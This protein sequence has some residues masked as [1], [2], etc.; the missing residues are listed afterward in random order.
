MVDD[1]QNLEK[2]VEPAKLPEEAIPSSLTT[3]LNEEDIEA[4]LF[5]FSYRY[6]NDK[7]C[8]LNCLNS[9]SYKKALKNFRVIGTL[10]K[11]E[12]FPSNNIK[13][14]YIKPVG[15]YLKIYRGLPDGA[16]VFENFLVDTNRLFYFLSGNIFNIVA[17]TDGHYETTKQ[18]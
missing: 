16:D 11:R 6:Y 12:S 2:V 18:R 14:K 7:E 9:G 13:T 5:M 17:I 10:S 8:G 4:G 3:P 15:D 1:L